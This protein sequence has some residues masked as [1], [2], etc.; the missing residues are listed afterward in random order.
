MEVNFCHGLLSCLFHDLNS[1][2]IEFQNDTDGMPTLKSIA[3]EATNRAGLKIPS[4][5]QQTQMSIGNTAPSISQAG[6]SNCRGIFGF[7]GLSH[8]AK[9]L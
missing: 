6:K 7:W 8:G 9:S 5:A 3:Q 1:N 4:S 2:E